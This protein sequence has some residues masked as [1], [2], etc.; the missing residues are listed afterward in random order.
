MVRLTKTPAL[1]DLSGG[2]K[3]RPRFLHC[4]RRGTVL[5][6]GSQAGIL[7]PGPRGAKLI[8]LAPAY[9]ETPWFGDHLAEPT[10]QQESHRLKLVIPFVEKRY[11]KCEGM[12]RATGCRNEGGPRA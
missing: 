3:T 10:L 5:P 8:C 12:S 9:D 1:R 4:W 11:P 2:Q 7:C 6:T